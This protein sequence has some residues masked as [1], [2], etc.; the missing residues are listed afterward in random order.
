MSE[1]FHSVLEIREVHDYKH[2]NAQ[3]KGQ[4]YKNYKLYKAT[5]DGRP[6]TYAN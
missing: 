3:K 2:H 5:A 1:H 6:E 4:Q